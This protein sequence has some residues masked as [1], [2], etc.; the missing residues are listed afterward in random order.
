[1]K[2]LSYKQRMFLYFSILFTV[3]SVGIA[4]LEHFRE[5]SFKTQALEEKLEAYTDVIHAQ[6]NGETGKIEQRMGAIRTILPADLRVTILDIKGSVKYDNSI[7]YYASLPNHIL[8]PEIQ[9]ALKNEKGSDIRKSTSNQQLYLYFAK[10][11]N[12]LFVRVAL[13]YTIQL[14][15]FLKANNGF[16][17]LILLFFIISL[18]IIQRITNRFGDSVQQL[19]DFAV[20]ENKQKLP[21]NF[22]KDEVGEVGKIITENYLQLEKNKEQLTLEKQKL[23]QHIQISEEGICFVSASNT[24]E[25]YNALFIQLLSLLSDE[26]VSNPSSILTDKTFE[27]LHEYLANIQTNYFET[28]ISKQGK[29]V[30]LRVNVFKDKSYEIILNDVTQQEKTRLLKQEMTGNIAHEL[31]TPIAGIRAY[32]ETILEQN[33]PEDKKIHFTQQAYQQTIG[34]SE[35]IKDMSFLSKMEEAP[36]SL[37]FEQLNIS[38]LLTKLKIKEEHKLKDKNSVF[39]WSIPE[40]LIIKGNRSLMYAIFRNLLENAIRYA[41]NNSTITCVLLKEDEQFYYFSFYDN[42]IGIKD[43][44][45]LNRLFERFYRVHEGRTRD[46]GG[47]GLGLSIVKNAVLFHKGKIVVKNRKEGG[48]EFLFQ[49]AK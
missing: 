25:F 45:H 36:E 30:S 22:P 10:K 43:E 15:N 6:L 31:R 17:Y 2:K 24:I 18:I 27:Q 41:G 40:G 35:M 44:N 14:Q 7:P 29:I 19:R 12:Q 1:M 21:I 46:S 23:L 42:G 37:E 48:L 26:I 5:H 3:F 16:L 49:L 8:R 34:L 39:T 47:S 4:L 38:E 32:L 13:P 11:S 9:D 20:A 28:K 33:L